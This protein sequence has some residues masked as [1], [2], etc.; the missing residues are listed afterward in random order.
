MQ[1]QCLYER[2][3][4]LEYHGVMEKIFGLGHNIADIVSPGMRKPGRKTCIGFV[5]PGRASS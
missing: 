2:I 3:L 1:D 5:Y 4:E